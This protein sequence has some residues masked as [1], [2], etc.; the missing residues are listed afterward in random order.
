[1]LRGDCDDL[2][3]LYQEIA[4]RQGRMAHMIG[5]P[6]HAALA[7]SEQRQRRHAG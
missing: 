6:A 4:A 5:L 3:E 7:W 2:S 1:M